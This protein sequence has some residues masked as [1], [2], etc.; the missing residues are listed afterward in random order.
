MSGSA[1]SLG[2]GDR[3]GPVRNIVLLIAG[4]CLFGGCAKV[5]HMEQLLT[6]KAAA[7]EQS[8]IATNV[9]ERDRKFDLMVAEAKAGT[10][11][12]YG[13]K[14]KIER[15]FGKP[16]YARKAAWGGPEAES[17]LYRYATEYFQ[18]DKIYLYFN[19]DG[20]L[21]RSEFLEN[22]NGEVR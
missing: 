7:D 15:V 3:E 16:V 20:N 22:K 10:L 19:T 1:G 13:N 18:A 21:V 11:D 5:S 2:T 17:W 9:D 12:Q 6:L 8:Q 4:A 14:R